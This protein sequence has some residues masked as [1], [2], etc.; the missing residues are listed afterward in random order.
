MRIRTKIIRPSVRSSDV[1]VASDQGRIFAGFPA[2][3]AEAPSQD[4]GAG[5]NGAVGCY[6]FKRSQKRRLPMNNPWQDLSRI[7]RLP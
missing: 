7:Q 4:A 2:R 3:P 1:A 6:L 5:E